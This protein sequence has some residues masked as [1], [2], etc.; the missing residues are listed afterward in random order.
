MAHEFNGS[1][2]REH[3][4]HISFPLGG[5]GAGMICLEGAGAL[6]HFSLR[7]KPEVFH[8]PCTF[9]AIS[10]EGSPRAARVLEGPVPG[11]KLFGQPGTGNGAGGASFG[12]PRFREARFRVRF[13][14]ATV[15]LRDKDVP[16]EVEITGWSP[17]EP[18]DADSASLPVAALEYRF[19]NPSASPV[20]AVFSWSARNFMAIRGNP[21]AVRA[22]P[23]GFV[24][25]G[26]PGK[27]KP[28]EEG[29]FSAT[30]ND[31]AVKVNHA[32]FRGGWFDPLTMAWKDVA[33][34]ACLDRPPVS[35]GGP[36][37]GAT[38]FVPLTLAPGASKTVVLR[39]AWHAGQT[40][41]RAGKDPQGPAGERA[42]RGTYRPWYAG[43]FKDIGEVTAHWRDHY[44]EL[45]GKARRFSDCFYD[46]TLPPEVVDAAAANLTILKSPTVL[47]QAGSGHGKVA[48]T[49]PV[50]APAPARTSGTTRRPFPTCFLRWS[51]RCGRPNSARRRTSAGTSSSAAR[52]RSGPS[53]TISTPRP[54]VSSAASSRSIASGGSAAT[55]SGS[56]ASGRR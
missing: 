14:F 6:S 33:A 35:E 23:G 22:T 19:T 24:L 34:G 48:A 37:P 27:D 2:S 56:A 11:W 26:G 41:L 15:T 1:Y 49:T 40:S 46:T 3:T 13:P 28:H 50:A 52:C 20:R 51:G 18:G 10:V 47:R 38:L 32:W 17:F 45:R 9:A 42:A 44:D 55:P 54:T 7:N 12:L 4:A 21:E 16:L 8:E 30:V 31:P 25:W 39:L 43:R 53:R 36:S 5:M 29:A